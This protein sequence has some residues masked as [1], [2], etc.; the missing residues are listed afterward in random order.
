MNDELIDDL[1]RHFDMENDEF[2]I[3][4]GNKETYPGDY[5]DE[6]LKIDDSE[7]HS[8]PNLILK[9]KLTLARSSKTIK[10]SPMNS[11]RKTTIF[12]HKSPSIKSK[13]EPSE[14]WEDE[15]D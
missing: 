3:M 15:Y 14:V 2:E 11:K 1:R 6:E 12:F 13:I 10:L 8:P 9:D 7:N 4:K 5:N